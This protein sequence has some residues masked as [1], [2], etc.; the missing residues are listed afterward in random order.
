MTVPGGLSGTVSVRML[1]QGHDRTTPGDC[2]HSRRGLGVRQRTHARPADPRTG[3]RSELG[4]GV[5]HLQ[6]PA[7]SEVP[8]RDRQV[9]A[10]AVWVAQHR[11]EQNL[12][13]TR[14]AITGDSVGGD[15]F[16]GAHPDGQAAR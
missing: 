10:A 13:P 9:H 1:R 15:M 3:G 11:A 16:R 8:D 4:G 12:D 5:P 2:P 14:I 7:G 6:S